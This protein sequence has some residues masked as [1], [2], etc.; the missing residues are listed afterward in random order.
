MWA[1][2]SEANFVEVSNN[3]IIL[4]ALLTSTIS[5]HLVLHRALSS[6]AS[7]SWV[8]LNVVVWAELAHTSHIDKLVHVTLWL[9]ANGN[10]LILVWHEHCLLVRATFSAFALIVI[11]DSIILTQFTWE[12]IVIVNLHRIF[13]TC[14]LKL[15]MVDILTGRSFLINVNNLLALCWTNSN[16]SEHK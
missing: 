10:L 14:G 16:K 12:F 13:A 7:L 3:L 5:Q 2:W 15:S 4:W 9:L 6:V 1:F 8:I 11:W